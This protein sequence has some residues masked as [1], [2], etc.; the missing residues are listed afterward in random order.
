VLLLKLIEAFYS[1]RVVMTDPALDVNF[2]DDVR[3]YAARGL[4]CFPFASSTVSV[5]V[6]MFQYQPQHDELFARSACIL[7]FSAK[8]SAD[9]PHF[10]SCW[11]GT[12]LTLAHSCSPF[13]PAT[14]CSACVK[15]Y[16]PT[17]TFSRKVHMAQV[18][19]MTTRHD[20]VM[21]VFESMMI[22]PVL[23]SDDV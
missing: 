8:F 15:I 13:A 19:A 16:V 14:R 2:S 23:A 21:L 12:M 20:V 17:K 4:P 3:G 7:L 1:C 22:R 18:A 9:S 5:A 10:V 11:R 6:R